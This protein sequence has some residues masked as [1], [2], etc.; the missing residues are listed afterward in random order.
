MLADTA[1]ALD[2]T[3]PLQS[4]KIGKQIG[5]GGDF[6]AMTSFDATTRRFALTIGS[7]AVLILLVTVVI[8]VY[9]LTRMAGE[10]NGIE[11][12]VTEKSAVA[13]IQSDLR[14]LGETHNDY[15]EWDDAVRVL[16]GSMDAGWIV[17]NI[18]SS[19]L[20]DTVYIVD[21]DGRGIL[22][23]QGG[24][25]V[26]VPLSE[27]FGPSLASMIAELPKDGRTYTFEDRSGVL[28]ATPGS[29]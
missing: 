1:R 4:I 17:D 9:A 28:G 14:R 3:Y 7:M 22:G 21:E 5:G 27:A 29:S 15:A 20:F 13:A 18:V 6:V 26:S 25:P 11:N 23:Y 24:E 8:V 12:T 19:S 16:Y 10:V 2:W